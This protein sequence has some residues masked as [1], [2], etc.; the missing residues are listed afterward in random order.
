MPRKVRDSNLETRTARARLKVRH[1]PYFRLIE[2]GL[3]LGYRRLTGPGPWIERRYSG[4]GRYAVENLRTADGALIV[5]DDYSEA[6]GHTVLNFGQAQERI[7]ARRPAGES[8]TDL[9]VGQALE[10]YIAVRDKRD[11]KRKGRPVR[12][13]AGQ[14]LRRYVLGQPRRGEQPERPAA[15]LAKVTLHALED[16]NLRAWRGG[17]PHTLTAATRKRLINDLKAALNAAYAEHRKQL[18]PA[19]QD[20]IKYGLKAEAES[21]DDEEG[22]DV[23]DSQVLTDSQ[24]TALLRAT[25]DID[26][27]EGWDGDLY[28]LVAVMAAT[29]ARFSQVARL[30]VRDCQIS[31]ARLMVPDSR[32][33]RKKKAGSQ[34]IPVGQDIIAVLRPVTIRRGKEQWLLERW[35][36][37]Q[38]TGATWKRTERGPWSTS[39]LTRPWRAI[40]E[41]AGIPDATPYCLRH[42][43]IVRGIRNNLPIRLVA[44]AHDT[45]VQIIERHYSRFIVGDLEKLLASVVVPLLPQREEE[46]Q[47][48]PM[49][50][51]RGSEPLRGR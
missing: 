46:S 10:S 25:R 41:R 32:K 38:V 28:R 1:K 50:A 37:E 47:V 35:R 27:E 23:P 3:H 31:N 14:R 7:K 30:R 8:P 26:A 39:E 44:S 40:R 51:S 18:P 29:G 20:A 16:T 9:T 15:P 24:I 49:R 17:L 21:D 33:G 11:T 12:S 5:A 48:V 42:S 36:F 34:P 13:D 43:S 4:Q 45:S 6:D 22:A 2:P 19:V